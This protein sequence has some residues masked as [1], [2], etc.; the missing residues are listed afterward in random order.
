M[1]DSDTDRWGGGRAAAHSTRQGAA[2]RYAAAVAVVAALAGT[3]G[4]GAQEWRSLRSAR[5]LHDTGAYD[6]RVKYAAGH[7]DLSAAAS[8]FLYEMDLYYDA[9]NATAIHTLGEGRV[10][11]LG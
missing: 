7:L 9:V 3:T 11:T 2:L 4:A 1:A 10:L 6:V 8:P 5:Q